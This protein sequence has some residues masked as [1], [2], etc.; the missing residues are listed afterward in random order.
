MFV[1]IVKYNRS[2]RTIHYEQ[3]FLPNVR[4]QMIPELNCMI[5]AKY[6]LNLEISAAFIKRE[7]S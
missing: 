7:P 6:I 2:L 1:L 3:V 4:R 5:I